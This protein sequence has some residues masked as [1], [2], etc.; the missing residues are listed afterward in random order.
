M[1]IKVKSQYMED[2]RDG[3]EIRVRFIANEPERTRILDCIKSGTPI[4]DWFEVKA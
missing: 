4:E 2:K 1:T 3:L